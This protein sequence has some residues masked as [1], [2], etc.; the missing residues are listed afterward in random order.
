MDKKK[1]LEIVI[2]TI[3][4]AAG[5]VLAA[6]G[7]SAALSSCTV[8]RETNAVGKAVIVTTDTTVINHTG[9]IKFPKK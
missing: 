3:I 1:V 6:L 9:S 4:Y 7:A 2:K 5:L 8:T